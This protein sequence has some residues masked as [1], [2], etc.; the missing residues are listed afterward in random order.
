MTEKHKWRMCPLGQHWRKGHPRKGTKGVKGHCVTNSSH[1]DQLYSD[2]IILISEKNFQ[3]LKG[4]ISSKTLG[5][6]QGKKFDQLI[7]GWCEYWNDIFHDKTPIDP[8]LVK[9]LIASESGFRSS[10]KIK[11]GKG[12]GFAIGL[13]QVTSATQ[14]ILSDEN[15]ELSDHLVNVDQNELKYPSLNIASGIRWMFYKKKLISKKLKREIDW[16]EAIMH[17]KGYKK[18]DHPQMKKLI[19]YYQEL[20]N[21]NI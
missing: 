8:N 21:E 17:Y 5:F 13:M 15:G 7:L 10:I 12:Q 9:A 16:T 11:D 3:N 18:L 6:P 1:K 20:S 2:E 4:N 19:K 14:K